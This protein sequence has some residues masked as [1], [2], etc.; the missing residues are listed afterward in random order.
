MTEV[1]E[2]NPTYDKKI[3]W[4]KDFQKNHSCNSC[5]FIKNEVDIGV[6]MLRDCDLVCH[7]EID[8]ILEEME[9]AS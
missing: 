4:A 5:P 7:M 6:G 1:I 3:Q 8:K 2:V 9:R